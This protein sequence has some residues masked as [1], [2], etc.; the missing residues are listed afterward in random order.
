MHPSVTSKM[1]DEKADQ[2]AAKMKE[3][4]FA[5]YSCFDHSFGLLFVEYIFA[6]ISLDYSTCCSTEELY[7]VRQ[8]CSYLLGE[9]SKANKWQNRLSGFVKVEMDAQWK[10]KK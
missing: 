6:D 9:K 3:G 5:Q 4:S 10:V 1:S 2:S 8:F 7:F